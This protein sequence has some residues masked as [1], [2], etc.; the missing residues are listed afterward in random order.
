MALIKKTVKA[1]WQN[2]DGSRAPSPTMAAST[3][4]P[5]RL[6]AT[7]PIGAVTR[8]SPVLHPPCV[9]TSLACTPTL[10]CISWL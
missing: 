5:V 2:R 7:R 6:A 3:R 10:K 4:A 9:M 8:Y 1:A